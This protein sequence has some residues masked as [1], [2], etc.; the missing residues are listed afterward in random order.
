MTE[1]E[2]RE[3]EVNIEMTVAELQ[4]KIPDVGF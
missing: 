4:N 3:S 2:K 1:S